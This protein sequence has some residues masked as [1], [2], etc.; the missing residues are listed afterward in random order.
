MWYVIGKIEIAGSILGYVLANP[1]TKQVQVIAI[2]Q[3]ANWLG[4]VYNLG[5]LNGKI[6][7]TDGSGPR[8]FQ[9]DTNMHI[10]QDKVPNRVYIFSEL[11][12]R[13]GNIYSVFNSSGFFTIS[14]DDLKNYDGKVTLINGK[15]V[16]Q[17]DKLVISAL[18]GTFPKTKTQQT[19]Q[20]INP[21]AATAKETINPYAAATKE[22]K[23]EAPKE[24]KTHI[25]FRKE[26]QEAILGYSA[27]PNAIRL[28]GHSGGNGLARVYH[29]NAIWQRAI[30]EPGFIYCDATLIKIAQNSKSITQFIRSANMYFIYLSKTGK[31]TNL[32]IKYADGKTRAIKFDKYMLP[33]EVK[34]T[35]ARAVTGGMYDT[36]A[37]THLFF[38][39]GNLRCY[40]NVNYSIR[41]LFKELNVM[42][43]TLYMDRETI[44]FACDTQNDDNPNEYI[45][46]KRPHVTKKSIAGLKKRLVFY[47]NTDYPE[48]LNKSIDM[49]FIY[50]MRFWFNYI[51]GPVPGLISERLAKFYEDIAVCLD[52]ESTPNEVLKYYN[53]LTG[54]KY[55]PAEFRE[56][57]KKTY[58][59]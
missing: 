27:S 58:R 5:M 12:D 6:D 10:I 43:R 22:E 40:T 30:Q 39:N 55:T 16:H 45:W 19:A 7:I 37:V 49:T 29:N 53:S 1:D 47:F 42:P 2:A 44:L 17:D 52:A 14:E 4:R 41:E 8:L 34:T 56:Y 3:V 26:L 28:M 48:T 23:K 54:S 13:K 46:R 11:L 35:I 15:F 33:P 51:R 9:F 50:I 38:Y 20:N 25:Q 31:K 59:T 24:K 21:Y 36:P 57:I 18:R 32:P